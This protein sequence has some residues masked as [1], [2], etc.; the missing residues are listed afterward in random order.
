MVHNGFAALNLRG[1]PLS[2]LTTDA[3]GVSARQGLAA[4]GSIHAPNAFE[5]GAQISLVFRQDYR[6]E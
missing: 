2:G 3:Q 5:T 4:S 6:V 1:S